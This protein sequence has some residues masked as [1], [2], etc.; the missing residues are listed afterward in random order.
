MSKQITQ[1]THV[2]ITA[3]KEQRKAQA[4]GTFTATSGERSASTVKSRQR[5]YVSVYLPQGEHLI[6]DAKVNTQRLQGS[7]ATRESN[8]EYNLARLGG[9]KALVRVGC[10]EAKVASL[11]NDASER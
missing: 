9:S 5:P 1:E 6:I 3:L 4:T 7:L 10:P 11:V 8:K 2:L